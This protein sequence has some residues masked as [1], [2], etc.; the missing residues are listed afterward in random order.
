METKD[1]LYYYH[2]DI[3]GAPLRLTDEAGN[4]V[5]NVHYDIFGKIDKLKINEVHNPIRM[6]GQY[7]DEETGLYYNRYRYY[8]PVISAYVGQDPLGLGAGENV[9]SYVKNSFGWIDPLGLCSK[10]SGSSTET[11]NDDFAKETFLPD[12]YYE[13]NHAPMQGTPG[14]RF[15][16][17]RLGSS[18]KIE[19]SRVIYDKGG[20]QIYRTDYSDHNN[21]FHHT[22]PHL[23]EYIYQDAGKSLKAK[24]TYFL[25]EETGR[26]RLGEI[27]QTTNRIKFID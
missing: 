1:K 26:L 14:D 9:Y 27:D 19:E 16:F 4:I 17:K 15:D 22:D 12:K 20:K 6:Q 18:G 7:E 3:N 13:N 24:N 10:K 21:R 23:H 11:K 2:N 5:W 25:E 8:D